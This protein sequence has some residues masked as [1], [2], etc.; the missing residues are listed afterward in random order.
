MRAIFSYMRMNPPTVGHRKVVD[1]I[2]AL[3]SE[4]G[5]K[6]RVYLSFS[7]D[8]QRNP[9]APEKK[10]HFVQSF[11]PDIEVKLARNLFEATQDLGRDGFKEAVMVV[12]EDRAQTFSKLFT[13]YLGTSELG[14]DQISVRTVERGADDASATM[15]RQAVLNEDWATF[16]ALSPLPDSLLTNELYREVQLGMG[17]LCPRTSRRSTTHN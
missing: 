7:H 10:L 15:A 11:F 4:S 17:D 3:A 9:L 2:L 12:G 14:L 5:G 16:K 1:T 8:N 6:S 13:P